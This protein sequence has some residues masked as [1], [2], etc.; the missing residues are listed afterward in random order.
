MQTPLISLSFLSGTK[1]AWSEMEAFSRR[2][3][4]GDFM[5]L[6]LAAAVAIAASAPA[7]AA[8]INAPVP[9]NAYVSFGGLDWAWASPCDPGPGGT[10][11]ALDLSYQGTQG[12][13]IATAADFLATG[14]TFAQFQ[15]EGANVPAAGTEAGT[16]AT[17]FGAN[18]VA[19]ACATPWFSNTFQHCDFG[20]GQ[21]G[22]VWN[23]PGNVSQGNCCSETWVVRGQITAV[24]EPRTW[25]MLI[26][27]FGLVGAIQRRRK[28]AI[29]G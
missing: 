15:F 1:L 20:D 17:F 25:A 12:W 2:H 14:M 21:A 10:C 9:T 5:R 11:G 19:T 4:M 16:G 29:A 27:G 22:V 28:T 24:P 18:P 23:M 6:I 3:I 8:F 7:A 26:A 13:R